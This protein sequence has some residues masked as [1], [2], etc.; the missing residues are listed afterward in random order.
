[1]ICYTFVS[2][3]IVT[4]NKLINMIY[5]I[6]FLPVHISACVMVSISLFKTF[7]YS[8]RLFSNYFKTHVL[9]NNTNGTTS[10][11]VPVLHVMLAF[12]LLK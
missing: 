11:D 12:K 6:D 9:G 1:M 5:Y 8:S 7:Q 10:R 2:Q 3:H 4:L